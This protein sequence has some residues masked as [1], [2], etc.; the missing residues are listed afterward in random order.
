MIHSEKYFNDTHCRNIKRGGQESIAKKPLPWI[1][2]EETLNKITTVCQNPK[3]DYK[4]CRT[5]YFLAKYLT[6]IIYVGGRGMHVGTKTRFVGLQ[7]LLVMISYL[8]NAPT[9]CSTDHGAVSLSLGAIWPLKCC[10]EKV[11]L[12]SKH[13]KRFLMLKLF[14]YSEFIQTNYIMCTAMQS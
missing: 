13:Y 9:T 14:C 1:T 5:S 10:S 12:N 11:H 2:T 7:F 4:H 6:I 8:Y 3:T